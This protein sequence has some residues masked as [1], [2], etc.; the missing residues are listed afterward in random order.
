MTPT[1]TPIMIQIELL[2]STAK[3]PVN[4]ADGGGATF[5]IAGGV[6]T[7]ST[8]I[9][10]PVTLENMAVALLGLLVALAIADCTK[11]A[12]AVGVRM[13][14]PTMTLPDNMSLQSLEKLQSSS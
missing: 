7:T 5:A 13:R 11:A 2:V 10:T 14:T 8:A 3:A 4:S 1:M 9:D 6:T 12:V